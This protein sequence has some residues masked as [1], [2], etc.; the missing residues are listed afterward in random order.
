MFYVGIN[1]DGKIFHSFAIQQ[2]DYSSNM[3]SS[4]TWTGLIQCR[5][6]FRV[7]AFT[8]KG[9]GEAANLML[10]TL[11]SNGNLKLLLIFMLLIII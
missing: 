7:V 6:Q 9:P 10:S 2:E 4:Y 1:S 3:S 8:S 5:H 11:P